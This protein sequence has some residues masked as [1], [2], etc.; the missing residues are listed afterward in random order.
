MASDRSVD[1]EQQGAAAPDGM[2]RSW[3]DS[4][5][6]PPKLLSKL[7][8]FLK[9][10]GVVLALLTITGS[11]TDVGTDEVEDG[12]W[13]DLKELSSSAKRAAQQIQE[14]QISKQF[15]VAQCY[16]KH[17]WVIMYRIDIKEQSTVRVA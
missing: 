17:K 10:I 12:F 7:K 8:M 15:K 1:G 16:S 4:Q 2:W 5:V 9:S 13:D 3:T 14:S 11:C 6:Q